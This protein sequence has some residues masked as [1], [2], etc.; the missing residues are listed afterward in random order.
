MAIRGSFVST[1]ALD[2]RLAVRNVIRQWRR[3]RFG[4]VSV[5]AGVAAMILAGGFIDWIYWAM[6]ENTIGS[7]LGHVQV[8]RPGYF[9]RGTANPFT[10]LLP[11]GHD[12]RQRIANIP[13]VVSVAPRLSFSG[14]ISHGDANVS[15]LAEGIDPDLEAPF[16]RF[17][18]MT[19]GAA[20]S[21][22]ALREIV[23]GKGLADNLGIKPGDQVALLV[24][25]RGG[26]I[27][28]MEFT[29][30]GLF[31]TATKAYDDSALRLHIG[32]ARQ[33]VGASSAHA[34]VVILDDTERT[35]EVMPKIRS[36]VAADRLEVVA[37]HE[38][39]DFYN[40]TVT[41]FSK[42]VRVLKLIIAAIIVL[43]ISNTLTMSVLERTSEIGT[44]MALGGT[45]RTILRR[46]VGE[47][48]VLGIVGGILGMTV[49][50]VLALVIS[51]VGIPMPAPPGMARGFVGEVRVSLGLVLDALGLAVGTTLLASLYPAWRASRMVIVDA[52]RHAR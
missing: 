50:V 32:A 34:W 44:M 42:Q 46:F 49:G 5:A 3:S 27:S 41:L 4:L 31:S 7:R 10:Y 20:L 30:R 14:L 28:A 8:V 25:K 35:D 52:L 22:S 48:A 43:S 39:A 18:V 45:R 47:G 16:D 40:K 11:V 15:F 9:D 33:L 29:V 19:S 36:L 1:L 24:N 51:A 26:G 17:V 2:A 12:V 37:W 21:A 13:G 6:R 23:V 38:L